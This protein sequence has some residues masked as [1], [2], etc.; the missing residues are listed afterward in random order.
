MTRRVFRFVNWTLRPDRDEDAPPITYA[1]RCL[2]L[3]D[4]DT[5]C[6]AKS[7]PSQDPTEPQDW[8]FAHMRGH[9]EHTSYAE[10][11]ERPYVMWRGDPA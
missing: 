9:P 11:I 10:M 1:L 6:T 7:E 5:E 3:N 4:D 2:T 8:A